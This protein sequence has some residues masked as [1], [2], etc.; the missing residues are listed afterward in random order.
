MDRP[1]ERARASAP[2]GVDAARLTRSVGAA[3][4]NSAAPAAAY[5]LPPVLAL[6]LLGVGWELYVRIDGD[7]GIHTSR[8]DG[9]A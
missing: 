6:F 7:A 8:A 3:L 5:S 9:G 4:W 2:D 1:L